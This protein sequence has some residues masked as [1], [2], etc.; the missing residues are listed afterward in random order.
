[1]T[2]RLVTFIMTF[3]MVV[4][5]V[6]VPAQVFAVGNHQFSGNGFN[7]NF[8]VHSSW[9]DGYN[10]TMEIM[11]TSSQPIEEWSIVANSNLGLTASGV[12][13]GILI[14]QTA[15]ATEI[16]HMSWNAVIPVGGQV[17]I[18]LVGIHS[19]TIP[20]PSSLYAFAKRRYSTANSDTTTN[21]NSDATAN[22][23]PATYINLRYANRLKLEQ[24]YICNRSR[25]YARNKLIGQCR[26]N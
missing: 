21:S 8:N 6:T 25:N 22:S 20:V 15:S 7:V 26:K 24:Y 13:G 10:A 14:S 16:G 23:N 9:N 18:T 3:I 5:S 2:K 17:S 19:G 11:N 12:S 4:T 1:M